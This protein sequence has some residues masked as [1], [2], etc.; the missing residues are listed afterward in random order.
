MILPQAA[1]LVTKP[2][3]DFLRL[4]KESVALAIGWKLEEQELVAILK[5]CGATAATL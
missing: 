2:A 5:K 3:P 1:L 4:A